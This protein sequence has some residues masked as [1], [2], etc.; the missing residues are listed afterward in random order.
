MNP[1]TN[2]YK[3]IEAAKSEDNTCVWIKKVR[4]PQR[5]HEVFGLVFIPKKKGIS[6]MSSVYEEVLGY[7]RVNYGQTGP[8][9]TGNSASQL[10]TY[11]TNECNLQ[12]HASCRNGNQGKNDDTNWDNV[13]QCL[14]SDYLHEGGV[15]PHIGCLPK[16]GE[17]LD[18]LDR[19]K[20]GKGTSNYSLKKATTTKS[21]GGKK[22]SKVDIHAAASLMEEEMESATVKDD[23]RTSRAANRAKK[24]LEADAMPEEESKPAAKENESSGGKKRKAT[25]GGEKKKK[26]KKKDPNA[27]KN[28][29][30]GKDCY[31]W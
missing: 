4:V 21:G 24:K 31:C 12:H 17:G 22:A 6:S 1:S 20:K 26:K 11:L 2:L 14:W 18:P 29:R 7:E 9:G 15:H 28:K 16:M 23:K 27:P 13:P 19:N 25:G 3:V 30:S 5:E 10:K 8:Y